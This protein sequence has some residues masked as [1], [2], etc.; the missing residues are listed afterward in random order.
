MSNIKVYLR[1]KPSDQSHPESENQ[2]VLNSPFSKISHEFKISQSKFGKTL[3]I[4]S[5]K[6]HF[7]DKRFE[8][9]E[10][11]EPNVSQSQLFFQFQ[12][13]II[14]SATNGVK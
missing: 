10:I 1:I 13:K 6:K 7:N 4:K 9:E 2:H 12:D 8:F 11:F 5:D 3:S 14:E